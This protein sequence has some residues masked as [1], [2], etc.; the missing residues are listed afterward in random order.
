[1]TK[2]HINQHGNCEALVFKKL[3]KVTTKVLKTNCKV[4]EMNQ[5]S[6]TPEQESLLNELITSGWPDMGDSK[7]Y[8]LVFSGTSITR[9]QFE[10]R[11]GWIVWRGGEQP[12]GDDVLVDIIWPDVGTDIRIAARNIYWN[13]IAAY[14]LHKPK[15]PKG[16]P[17]AELM[18]Q[19]CDII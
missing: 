11:D 10:A 3:P 7:D 5:F 2:I 1:M 13:D 17:H 16:H 14:R 9:E 6:E 12:V 18:V 15:P 4:K 19:Y 8:L